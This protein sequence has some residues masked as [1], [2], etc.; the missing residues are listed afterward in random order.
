HPLASAIVR[1][2]EAR[3]ITVK[4]VT[5]FASKPGRGV[6]GTVGGQ[7]VA[8]GNFRLVEELGIDAASVAKRS[9]EMRREGQTVMFVVADRELVGLI[10]VSDPIKESTRE[11]I[12]GLHAQGIRVIVLTGDSRTTAEAVAR[13]LGLD[14]V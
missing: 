1:A 13:K 6:E 8:L 3:G 11:A 4:P 10:G 14:D 5:A 9:E 7:A 2:A 12:S